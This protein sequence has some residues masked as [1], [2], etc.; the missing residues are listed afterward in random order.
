M[1]ILTIKENKGHTDKSVT[2]ENNMTAI[3]SWNYIV[4][5]FNKYK[6][7][8]EDI[9]QH[10]WESFFS[11]SEL[12]KY[13]KIKGEVDSQRTLQVGSTKSVVPDIILKKEEQDI[14]IVE[15]KK[16]SL[17][18]S[19]EKESQLFSYL[20]LLHI[21]IG[22]LICDEIHIYEY[23]FAS[24]KHNKITIP[25]EKDTDDGISFVELFRKDTFS[26]EKIIEFI[27]NKR[28]FNSKVKKIQEQITSEFIYESVKKSLSS[29]FTNDEIIAA[30]KEYTFLYTTPKEEIIETTTNTI[31]KKEETQYTPA[32]LANI[33]FWTKFNEYAFKNNEFCKEFEKKKPT[34][35]HWYIFSIKSTNCSISTTHLKDRI[36]IEIYIPNNMNQY[37]KFLTNKAEIERTVGCQLEWMDL[38]K[39]KASRIILH[40]T[41]FD[42]KDETLLTKEFDW[43]IEYVF[44]FKKAFTPFLLK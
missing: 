3:E 20:K 2:K 1:S 34:N 9:V 41:E 13:S 18:F 39:K 26:T 37:E 12:F 33:N 8:N 38:P 7:A 14:F 27:N 35:R 16:Y 40:N 17:H 31:P 5:H 24:N 10:A 22:I 28:Q 43:I 6:N 21:P 25:F 36:G 11:D 29:E 4:D 42:M 19:H 32:E 30:I 23:D 44:K 15:L